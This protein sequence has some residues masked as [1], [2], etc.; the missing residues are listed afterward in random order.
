MNGGDELISLLSEL[1]YRAKRKGYDPVLWRIDRRRIPLLF[2]ELGSTP[3][4]YRA[5]SVDPTT[6]LREL[7]GI[8]VWHE[9]DRSRLPR[10][11]RELPDGAPQ[12]HVPERKT[13][14]YYCLECLEPTRGR[15]V[16]LEWVDGEFV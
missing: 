15:T 4:G 5:V 2:R 14:N 6:G 3:S 16:Y 12:F 1:F 9:E 10:L 7:L 8:K 13:P 11:H